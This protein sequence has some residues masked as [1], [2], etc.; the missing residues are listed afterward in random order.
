M[1]LDITRIRS[2]L[3]TRRLARQ[4][5]YYTE[6]TSTMNDARRLY[7]TG[8]TGIAVVADMQHAGRGRRGHH[9][10]SPKGRGLYLSCILTFPAHLPIAAAGFC[11]TLSILDIIRDLHI[12]DGSIKWPNDVL[13]NGRKVAGVLVESLHS[14]REMHRFTAGIGCNVTSRAD[15]FPSEL[16]ESVISLEE[17]AGHTVEREPVFCALMQNLE[18][19]WDE[20]LTNGFEPLLDDWSQNCSTIGRQVCITMDDSEVAGIAESLEPDG[21]LRV[22]KPDGTVEICSSG[23]VEYAS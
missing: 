20:V 13:V 23:M 10:I 12:S 11:C 1:L 5:T 16:Q 22:R 14:D 2:E 21:S 4:L 7:Q 8:D 19:R 3:R 6:T 17:A 15:D 18:N 9:W